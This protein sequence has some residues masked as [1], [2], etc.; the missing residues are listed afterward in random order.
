MEKADSVEDMMKVSKAILQKR[1]PRLGH[2][3]KQDGTFTRNRREVLNTLLDSFFP[4]SEE[5]GK[6][7]EVADSIHM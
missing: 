7:T 6:D 4:G 2:L 1:S 3:K 5:P